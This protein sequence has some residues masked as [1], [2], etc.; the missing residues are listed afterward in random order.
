[1]VVGRETLW[2]MPVVLFNFPPKWG[3]VRKYPR[4]SF[5]V[6]P[7]AVSIENCRLAQSPEPFPFPQSKALFLDRAVLGEFR[8][9]AVHV[10]DAPRVRRKRTHCHRPFISPSAPALAAVGAVAPQFRAPP[11]RAPLSRA[12]GVLPLD[13]GGKPVSETGLL[14]QPV[15]VG[16]RLLVRDEDH[17]LLSAPPAVV[18]RKHASSRRCEHVVLIE[19]DLMLRDGVGNVD[20]RSDDVR[21]GFVAHLLGYAVRHPLTFDRHDDHGGSQLANFKR[22]AKRHE[23][24]QFVA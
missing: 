4:R 17:G 20:H 5:Y 24:S 14:A 16:E 6:D 22:V 23:R 7:F 8:H 3:V 21:D 18:L 12:R 15:D 9:V 2:E 1:M 19:R 11:V 10:V 13:D